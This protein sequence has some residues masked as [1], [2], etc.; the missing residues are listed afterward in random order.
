MK[1]SWNTYQL[2]MYFLNKGLTWKTVTQRIGER[3]LG[4]GSGVFEAPGDRYD[5]YKQLDRE[6]RA[7][8]KAAGQSEALVWQ[9]MRYST[10]RLRIGDGDIR[11]YHGTKGPTPLLWD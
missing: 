8:R 10:H 3:E 7:A 4:M 6:Q 1:E 2:S 9:G 11:D 5:I